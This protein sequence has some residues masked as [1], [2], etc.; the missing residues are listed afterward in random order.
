[1]YLWTCSDH[2]CCRQCHCL[3]LTFEMSGQTGQW[4]CRQTQAHLPWHSFL[5]QLFSEQWS[6]QWRWCFHPSLGA[7]PFLSPGDLI[8][9][10][11]AQVLLTFNSLLVIW[12]P[13]SL[14]LMAWT[15]S[16]RLLLTRSSPEWQTEVHLRQIH[17]ITCI[18]LSVPCPLILS[19]SN[20]TPTCLLSLL[21]GVGFPELGNNTGNFCSETT[22]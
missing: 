13:L 15:S 10:A 2:S 3:H 11:D 6:F 8:Q 17:C 1:M 9:F 12:M 7:N 16:C 14:L 4:K 19:T 22:E 5:S 18:P 20:L 21:K